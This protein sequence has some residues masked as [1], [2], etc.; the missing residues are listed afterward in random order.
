MGDIAE[1]KQLVATMAADTAKLI[2]AISANPAAAAVA[3]AHGHV[4]PPAPDPAQLRAEKLAKLSLALRKSGKLKD[5]K[6]AQQSNVREW[7]KRFDQELLQ[8]SKMSGI[9]DAL[10]DREYVDSLKDKLDYTVV[11]RLDTAFPN[12]DPALTWNNVTKVQL[13]GVLI[14]EY[15]SKETDVSAVLLQFGPNRLKKTPD[16]SVAKFYHLWLE[17]LPECMLPANADENVKFVDLI[18]KALFY[19]CLEDKF[20]QE[21]LCNLKNDNITLKTFFDEACVAEQKRRSFQEIGVSSSHLDSSSGVSVNKWEARSSDKFGSDKSGAGRG[22]SG[23]R[24]RSGKGGGS[25]SRG[26]AARAR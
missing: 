11:K 10:T 7:L 6:D 26:E 3:P 4:A 25:D 22:K 1:L 15:G 16:M 5:F 21:Q 8:L 24:G 12:K 13:H 20:L 19:F 9:N 17:Q 18:K 14:E 2:A 23:W